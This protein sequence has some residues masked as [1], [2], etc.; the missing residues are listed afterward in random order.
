MAPGRAALATPL[1][2]PIDLSAAW[3]A[4]DED[5]A[6]RFHPR[7]AGALARL[8]DGPA[9]FRGLPF[10][11]GRRSLGRRW[12][13]LDR[14]LSIAIPGEGRASHLVVAHLADSA[15]DQDGERPPGTPVGWVLPTGEP[16]AGYE[17]AFADGGTRLFEI[18][19][20]FEIADGIIGWGFVPFAAVGHRA[21]EALDWRG[22]HARQAPGRSVA[23]GQAGLLAMLPGSW[24]AAQT[25]VVDFVPTPDDDATYW[26]HSIPLGPAA[27]PVAV[28]LVPLGG[29]RPGSAVA[30]AA[31]TLYDGTADPL[32]LTPRRQLL[33]EDGPPGLP[34]LDLGIAISSR[35]TER[36]AAA[37]APGPTGW[38]PPRPDPG[39]ASAEPAAQ[40]AAAI[41]DIAAARDAR[42]RLAGWEV[43]V[44]DIGSGV[45]SPDGRTRIR[46]LPPA[47]VRV[48]VRIEADDAA[49][50][51]R[52]R[53]I[54]ADGRYLPPLGHR[55]E[56]NP[57][58]LE[59]TGA[60]VV[61]GGATY[62]YVPGAFQIDLPL[63]SIQVE[64][65]KGFE[66]RPVRRTFV[67][68]QHT[69]D[70][71]IS[72][73]RALDLR[74]GGWRSADPHVH[75]LAPSTA[76]LQAA[77]EDVTFVHLLATQLGDAFTNVTDLAW[78]SQSDPDG[79]H[80]V[81]VGTENRQNVL[82]H[83]ALLGARR[84]ILPLASGASPEGRIGGAV[85]ELLGDWADRCHAEGGLVVAAHFPLPYA[86][87]A[88][89]IVAGQIDAVEMQTFAPGLD[90]PS[91]LEWYRFLNCGI[92]VP[93]LGGTD[94]MSA[95]MVLGGIRTYARLDPR[96]APTFAAW[97]DAVRAGRT[98]ATAGP[99]LELTVDGHEPGDVIR[100]RAGG[101]RLPAR[102]RARSA[103]PI[104]GSVELVM[105]GLV[106]AERTV[107]QATDDLV[108]DAE[109][110]VEA[111]AWIAARSRSDHEIHSA[112]N[113]SMAA[114]TS[115]VY[116]EVVD[117]PLFVA[118]DATAILAV[119]DGVVRWLETT[120]TVAE[121][122][123]RERM[124][125]RVG[126]SGATLRDRIGSTRGEQS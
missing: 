24:G 60:G 25:G 59:D 103:Q 79:R 29:D 26:L 14:E 91:I 57:G 87:I 40:A 116:V 86:E 121:P 94:K 78:G 68:D 32:Q 45:S 89:D 126:A 108:L 97:A 111:G 99:I 37:L 56:I 90:S 81:I 69:R 72:L 75:F 88:A 92:R 41:V 50:P 31:L 119:I 43:A 58:L 36:S 123:V 114:H 16:L 125:R 1:A 38:G 100:L 104:I 13:L 48:D 11:L 23:A 28:R 85:A 98:F 65:V 34:E 96:G 64:V 109:I 54:A 82:G 84:P 117:R 80:A 124:V 3:N 30:V 74:G 21:E 42:I 19:R 49:A 63:G 9:V 35:P 110:A 33:I 67:V 8:P 55:E 73:D 106:V 105:N 122:A 27:V 115:P 62:A 15:R 101:G 10:A 5:L 4:S 112:Y 7:Y 76:L 6:A 39:V 66:H 102:A 113:S 44:A 107:P 17:I 77:A 22:P 20:R 83:L 53:F 120:A 71:V 2:R 12:L 51:S 118:A 61:L 93:V 46:P 70:V 95:E 52:V 18:R 47:D